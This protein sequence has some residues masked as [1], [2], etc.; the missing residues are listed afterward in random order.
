[1]K[2]DTESMG[3]ITITNYETV[4][5]VFANKHASGRH[6]PDL[7]YNL[8]LHGHNESG[9]PVTLL[10][11]RFRDAH[12]I[13]TNPSMSGDRMIIDMLKTDYPLFA[14]MLAQTVDDHSQQKKTLIMQY[15]QSRDINEF[16]IDFRII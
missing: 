13:V 4:L 9:Q 11:I 10:D 16:H 3:T 6:E 5:S 1:M 14:M 2:N 8:L 12:R 7:V 15:Q